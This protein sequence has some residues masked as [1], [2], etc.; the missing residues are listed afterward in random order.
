MT[1]A[2]DTCELIDRA[3]GGDRA[4]LER[5][6]LDHY[7]VLARQIDQR[8]PPALRSVLGPDDLVQMTYTQ[9]FVRI[10]GYERRE[11]AT[12]LSWLIAIA[13]NRLRDCIRAQRRQKRGGGR[14]PISEGTGEQESRAGNLFD[15]IAGSG[16]TPSQSLAR[17]EGIQAIQIAVA[18]L[19]D[20]YR[21]AVELRYFEGRSIEETAG[22]MG[23]TTGAVRGL[24][25]RAKKELREALE[26]ASKY[27]S[28]K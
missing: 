6:M 19:P 2:A 21:Q 23:R 27:L 26:R 5:L 18:G 14:T 9:V 13:E 16:N 8:M 10:S 25:D 22:A 20:D 15:A 3:V 28:S 24:L 4:A 7:G 11:D 17:R 12:F 1:D